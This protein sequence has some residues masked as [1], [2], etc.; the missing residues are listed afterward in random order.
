[1]KHRIRLQNLW[2]RLHQRLKTAAVDR[3]ILALIRE[4]ESATDKAIAEAESA[5]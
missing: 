2:K 5:R 1:M 4:I 3:D